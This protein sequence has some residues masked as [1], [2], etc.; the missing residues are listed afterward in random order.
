AL[1][2][3]GQS[4][5]SGVLRGQEYNSVMEQTPALAMAIVKGLGVTTGE[6][7]QMAK[8]GKLT[9]DVI[10]PALEKAKDSV[11]KDFSTRVLTLSAAF[12]NL[13]TQATK[14]VGEANETTGAVRLLSEAV[15][16]DAENFD[17][18]AKG[19]LYIGGGTIAERLA[20]T[21]KIT[22]QQATATKVAAMS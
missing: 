14:W 21:A 15:G 7:R 22:Q 3:F 5:D 9:M 11:D 10:I 8:D 13:R 2:Q 18:L 16:T 12:E 17:L 1:V 4:I 6:L 19:I 20:N